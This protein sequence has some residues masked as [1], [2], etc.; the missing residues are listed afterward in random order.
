MWE[1][2]KNDFT[3]L[4]VVPH[5]LTIDKQK[6]LCDSS[7][8]FIPATDPTPTSPLSP[9]SGQQSWT[10]T[11]TRKSMGVT[12]QPTN[13][14]STGSSID[15]TM[16]D[17]LVELIKECAEGNAGMRR[18]KFGQDM[19]VLTDKKGGAAKHVEAQHLREEL[20]TWYQ[21]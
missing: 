21:R 15:G 1:S 12:S 5:K 2:I 7:S 14:L 6:I 13:F 11:P 19:V 9:K 20:N 4:G 17:A 8:R 16:Q 18:L 10:G 3:K